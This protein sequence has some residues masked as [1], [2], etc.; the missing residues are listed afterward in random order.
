MSKRLI[1]ARNE[2]VQE[3]KK[4]LPCAKNSLERTRIMIMCVYM[5]GKNIAETKAETKKYLTFYQKLVKNIYQRYLMKSDVI[6]HI[7]HE[8]NGQMKKRD[9]NLRELKCEKKL[10]EKK[11]IDIRD[12]NKGIN[13]KYGM[14][15]LH[16][17]QTWWLVKKA[18]CYLSKTI[19]KE[20]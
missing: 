9:E 8:D 1:P 14:Q 6:R 18:A 2:K 17:H 20:L 13:K 10:K 4:I 15:K 7:I 3:L 11:T 19:W 12:V 5:G 16:Y